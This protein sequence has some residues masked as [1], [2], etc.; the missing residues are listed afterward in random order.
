MERITVGEEDILKELTDGQLLDIDIE[1]EVEGLAVE[2][3]TVGFA[4]ILGAAVGHRSTDKHTS[5]SKSTISPESEIHGGLFQSKPRPA[6]C[7]NEAET[8]TLPPFD[9]IDAEVDTW[10]TSKPET[11]IMDCFSQDFVYPFRVQRIKL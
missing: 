9:L 11:H 7:A 1:V 10:L 2:G 5:S 4:D 6:I 8:S 3:N